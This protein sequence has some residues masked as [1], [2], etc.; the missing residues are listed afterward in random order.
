MASQHN[1][2]TKKNK[3]RSLHEGSVKARSF[4]TRVKKV[5]VWTNALKKKKRVLCV[6]CWLH[7]SG[8]W[9]GFLLAR[10]SKKGKH[11]PRYTWEGWVM[12]RCP[13]VLFSGGQFHLESKWP[14][15]RLLSP[16]AYMTWLRAERL[17]GRVCVTPMS[18]PEGRV[19]H[20]P[21]N[22]AP[23]TEVL[24]VCAARHKSSKCSDN[25]CQRNNSETGES[26]WGEKHAF[27]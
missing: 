4:C 11:I 5:T 20:N 17:R 10:K 3:L 7:Q 13:H 16:V 19:N 9:E 15:C 21:N 8:A 6:A 23:V 18:Q 25:K 26:R 12:E 22:R 24:S 1:T 2:H 14:A 27:H